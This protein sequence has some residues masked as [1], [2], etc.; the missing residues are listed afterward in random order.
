MHGILDEVTRG[1]NCTKQFLCLGF[2]KNF[3]HAT[4]HY[5]LE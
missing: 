5:Y 3:P 2:D 4:A 1:G